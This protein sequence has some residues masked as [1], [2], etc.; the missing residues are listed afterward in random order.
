MTITRPPSQQLNIAYLAQLLGLYQSGDQAAG[1]MLVQY[2]VKLPKNVIPSDPVR[3]DSK[4]QSAKKSTQIEFENTKISELK[5]SLSFSIIAVKSKTKRS[6]SSASEEVHFQPWR[7]EMECPPDN[8]MLPAKPPIEPY[9]QVLAKIRRALQIHSQSSEVNVAT[10]TNDLAQG[11]ITQHLPYEEYQSDPI[12]LWIYADFQSYQQGHLRDVNL[13]IDFLKQALPNMQCQVYSLEE[14]PQRRWRLNNGPCS[15]K[16]LPL[17]YESGS[18][19]L[20]ISQY[21]KRWWGEW[22]DVLYQLNNSGLKPVWLTTILPPEMPCEYRLVKWGGNNSVTELQLQ[23]LIGLFQTVRVIYGG[24]LRKVIQLLCLPADAETGFW[25]HA[26]VQYQPGPDKGIIEFTS[27]AEK[28]PYLRTV[29]GL[30]ASLIQRF[31][32]VVEPYLASINLSM[33]HE[34]RV[35]L[36]LI[37]PQWQS[38]QWQISVDYFHDMA[39]QIQQTDTKGANNA[40]FLQETVNQLQ[41]NLAQTDKKLTETLAIANAWCFK[42]GLAPQ[43]DN[44]LSE[45]VQTLLMGDGKASETIGVWSKGNAF[46]LE[47]LKNKQSLGVETPPQCGDQSAVF[48]TSM[49]SDAGNIITA[50]FNGHTLAVPAKRFVVPAKVDEFVLQSSQECLTLNQFN[51]DFFY[52]AKR[53]ATTAHGTTAETEHI[54]LIWPKDPQAPL[55]FEQWGV[56]TGGPHRGIGGGIMCLKKAAP[57]WLHEQRP[58]LDKFG[59]FC[60]WQIK[61]VPFNMRYIPPGS[62]LMGSPEDEPERDNDELQH[63][64]TVTQG[65]WLAETTVSQALWQAVM[66]KNPS[67]FKAN[68]DEVLP[69]ESVSWHDCQHFCQI[70]NHLTRGDFL[71]P[72]EAQWEYACRAGSQTPFNTGEQLTTEQANYCGNYPYEGRKRLNAVESKLQCYRQIPMDIGAFDPNS[73]GLKQ[74]HG[75]VWEWCLDDCRGR[76]AVAVT[77]PKGSMKSL[78]SALRGGSW[79]HSGRYCRS[80]CRVRFGHKDRGRDVGL[81]VSQVGYSR[82]SSSGS[83]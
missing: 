31:S 4:C 19:S 1:R 9:G 37:A 45:Q 34:H 47:P 74:L 29:A 80:A 20:I 18:Q 10:L 50:S 63:P 12:N 16:L 26:H 52:W 83:D 58:Q 30:S 39:G 25:Q 78:F 48:V 27:L 71:L 72:T 66:G 68:N 36:S 53:L 81:R 70:L 61:G 8:T 6:I 41:G 55:N 51:S 33:L 32:D 13:I 75:N 40:L 65:F 24:L 79:G 49:Q 23:H 17:P 69:V 44:Q 59:L 67:A 7:P 76:E 2:G 57:P 28:Q 73:W 38:P 64:V 60:E 22:Q 3:E 15:N 56:R 54:K 46:Y 21:H 35:H 43:V 11:K 77:D 42:Y 5:Q 82:E 14:G 62:F